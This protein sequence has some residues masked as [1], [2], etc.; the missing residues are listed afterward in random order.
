[1]FLNSGHPS[2]LQLIGSVATGLTA[3]PY[4]WTPFA[5][6][7]VQPNVSYVL[8]IEQSGRTNYSP[9]FTIRTSAAQSGLSQAARS[10]GAPLPVGSTR[11]YPTQKPW[12]QQDGEIHGF[13]LESIFSPNDATGVIAAPHDATR[14]IAP[15]HDAT[16][17]IMP[18]KDATGI[19]LAR[20]DAT[21]AIPPRTYAT[22]QIF[23]RTHPTVYPIG[24]AT[25]SF[26]AYPTGAP[27]S[28][29]SINAV[30]VFGSGG[31]GS[32]GRSGGSS[33]R[34]DDD[35]NAW[36]NTAHGIG[37][38]LQVVMIMAMAGCASLLL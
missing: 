15:R 32:G 10:Y 1:M 25:G 26:V 16:R 30:A 7:L 34:S 27:Y 19:I 23:P 14:I 28:N 17:V 35:S 20:H 33:S 21:G 37:I 12:V 2:K 4:T 31:R 38:D 3:S 18:R 5:S 29:A 36:D 13:D 9:C 22:G 11:Y 8:S 6:Q 24:T